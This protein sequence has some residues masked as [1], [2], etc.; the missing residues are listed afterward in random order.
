MNRYPLWKNLTILAV[1]LVAALYALPNIF[2]QDPSIEV[3]PLSKTAA[4]TDGSLTQVEAALKQADLPF[5]RI[6]REPD[7]LRIRFNDG[8]TQLK[9][10]DLLP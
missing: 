1:I 6:D 9:A 5:K 2:G 7:R 3:T 8:E 4:I 10:M